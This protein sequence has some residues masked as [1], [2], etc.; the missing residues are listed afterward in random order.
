MGT[1]VNQVRVLRSSEK[2]KF[3]RFSGFSPMSGAGGKP[4]LKLTYPATEN[5]RFLMDFGIKGG[6]GGALKKGLW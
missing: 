2:L 3:L 5:F 6:G 1:Q 4:R